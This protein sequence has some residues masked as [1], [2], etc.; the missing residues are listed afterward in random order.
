MRT[1]APAPL[2]AIGAALVAACPSP[3]PK[4]PYESA[5]YVA[6]DAGPPGAG[7]GGAESYV[8]LSRR[9][10]AAVGLAE[11]RGMDDALARTTVDRIADVLDACVTEQGR[12]GALVDGAARVVVLLSPD[13][14][15]EGTNVRMEPGG[16]IAATALRCLVS[17]VKLMTF[18]RVDAGA[19]GFAV[20]ALWGPA[21]LRVTAPR[22]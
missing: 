21:V 10:L 1:R 4:Q 16:A 15:V 5:E 8:Y 3:A 14:V 18:P 6:Y 22:R 20:E 7:P 19:R 12:S 2:L 13:G 17:P 11:A 9:P